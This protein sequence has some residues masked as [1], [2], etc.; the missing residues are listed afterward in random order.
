MIREEFGSLQ[1]QVEGDGGDAVKLLQPALD[2]TPERFNAIDVILARGKPLRTR[3]RPKV[4]IKTDIRQ[5][6]LAVPALQL[7]YRIGRNMTPNHPL[8]RGF[9][10]FR[11]NLVIDLSIALQQSKCNSFVVGTT[12]TLATHTA[13]TKV[14]SIN[15]NCA[16]QQRLLRARDSNALPQFGVSAIHR[17]LRNAGQLSSIG[18]GKIH[19]KIADQPPEFLLDDSRTAAVSIFNIYHKQLSTLCVCLTSQDL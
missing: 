13:M 3:T 15:L 2:V 10:A 5:P 14:R 12:A 19:C 9:G 8:Q 6:I 17:A 18:R 16:L 1:V 11:C 4:F 7:N